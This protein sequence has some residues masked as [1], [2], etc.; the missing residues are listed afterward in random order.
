MTLKT[1]TTPG[2]LRQ[3]S[4]Y[5]IFKIATIPGAL[6]QLIFRDRITQLTKVR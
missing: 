1:L 3:L 5:K 6:R 4:L 2:V